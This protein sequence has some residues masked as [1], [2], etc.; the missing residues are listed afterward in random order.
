MANFVK[1]AAYCA[2]FILLTGCATQN[3]SSTADD[4]SSNAVRARAHAIESL[5]TAQAIEKSA[6]SRQAL[7]DETFTNIENSCLK[8][9]LVNNCIELARINR[10]ETWD[11]A[12]KELTA[13]RFY[14]R[15]D[16][17]HKNQV[18]LT[19]KLANH[20]ADELANIPIRAANVAAFNAKQLEY[21]QRQ[22][23]NTIKK[24]SMAT[25]RT[26][27]IAAFEEKQRYIKEVQKKRAQDNEKRIT[28]AQAKRNAEL[29]Q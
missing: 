11:L 1:N 16:E 20:Q 5:E 7:A 18:T 22:L 10:N 28:E 8:K 29:S 2:I 24:V 17:A 23:N 27:N 21:E 15:T 26:A 3:L 19:K 4:L 6:L 13:A 25:E 9:F 12:Q 14:I